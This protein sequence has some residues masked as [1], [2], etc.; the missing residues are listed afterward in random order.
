MTAI[1]WRWSAMTEYDNYSL[2]PDETT[3]APIPDAGEE[4]DPLGEADWWGNDTQQA[5]LSDMGGGSE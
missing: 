2:D 5:T 3:A 1:R 4:F